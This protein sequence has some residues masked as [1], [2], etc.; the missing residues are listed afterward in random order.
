MPTITRDEA[1]DLYADGEGRTDDTAGS[2]SLVVDVEDAP[3]NRTSRWHERYWLVVRNADGELFGIEY[4]RGLTET[5]EDD[6]PWERDGNPLN[7]VPLV[8]EEVTT[9]RYRRAN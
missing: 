6:L 8:A 7:L 9:T 2:W 5:Q 3:H 4:G 1:G